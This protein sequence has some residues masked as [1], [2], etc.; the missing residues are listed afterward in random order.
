M[1]RRF[2]TSIR[3]LQTSLF[4]AVIVT[5]ILI[6]SGSVSAGLRATLARMAETSELRNASALAQRLESEFPLT[7]TGNQGVKEAVTDYR[8][9][10]GGGIWVYDAEGQLIESAYDAAPLA[11]ALEAA[12]VGGLTGNAYVRSDLTPNGW[13]VAAKALR[14]TEDQ[15]QGVVLTASSSNQSVAILR[16]VRGR[17]W[18]AFWVSLIVAGLLGFGFAEFIARRTRTMN[19]AAAAMAAGDFQQHLATRYLPS[20]L[21]DLAESYNTMA[22][23]LGEAFGAIQESQR[24]ISAVVE[25]MAEG[26][27]AVDSEG[28][29]RVINPEAARLLGLAD[30]EYQGRPLA[31]V[32]SFA[33]VVEVAG[34]ALQGVSDTRTAPLDSHIVLLHATPLLGSDGTPDGAV[35][36]LADVTEAQRIEEAQRR[37]VADASHEMRTPIAALQGMLELLIDGAKEVPAVRDDFLSTMQV[38]VERLGR[39]VADMLTLARLEAGSLQ[40]QIGPQY[41]ADLLADVSRVMQTLAEQAGVTLSTEVA[42]E[43]LRVLADRDKLVQVL[44][45]FTDNAIKHSDEGRSVHL[46]AHGVPEGVRFEV[47]DEGPGIA[48]DEVARVFERFYRADAARGGGTGTGLGLAIA[49]EIVEAHGSA[50]EVESTPGVGTAF[51]FTM[52]AA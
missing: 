18:S 50:I 48:P 20:E 41:A 35:M 33:E 46:R 1:P 6:L 10:Y 21:R 31:E 40:L 8:D 39:L 11:A 3:V 47:A 43:E 13:V 34:A 38:E 5:A 51:C 49:K 52:P 25:S 30:G 16:A 12:R 45:S 4:I 26:V 17:I 9:I 32:T 28:L 29:V 44:L 24:E 14:D 42:D 7:Q 22:T 19:A 2:G 36:L 15:V 23:R 37:F 27:I